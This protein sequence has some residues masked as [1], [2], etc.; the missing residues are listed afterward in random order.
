[1]TAV[2]PEGR[3]R[4]VDGDVPDG[5]LGRVG[6]DG[7]VA[8]VDAGDE[9]VAVGDVGAG[10]GEG[11]LGDGVVLVQEL[12]PDDISVRYTSEPAAEGEV[13]REES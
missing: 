12:E 2:E 6:G 9:A 4:V 7:L 10:G 1:M 3:G 5:E 11:G 13:I 8:R